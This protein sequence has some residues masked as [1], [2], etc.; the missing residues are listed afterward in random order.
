MEVNQ[1]IEGVS[2]EEGV[3]DIE[4]FIKMAKNKGFEKIEQADPRYKKIKPGEEYKPFHED[5]Y[6]ILSKKGYAL[7]DDDVMTGYNQNAGVMGCEC[8]V[9]N[10]KTREIQSLVLQGRNGSAAGLW[11]FEFRGSPV[12][13]STLPN[14]SVPD[15]AKD[16][17]N[18][19]K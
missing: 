9:F 19:I 1:K 18:V 15:V 16:V 7:E 12:V 17:S 14:D 8:L 6:K 5:T 2:L 3:V 10:P 11:K 4:S 13:E